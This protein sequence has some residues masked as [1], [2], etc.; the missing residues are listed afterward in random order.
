M[1]QLKTESILTPNFN[2]HFESEDGKTLI[3]LDVLPGRNVPYFYSHKGTHIA[4]IRL[5]NESVQAST[6]DLKRMVLEG[7][8]ETYDS[9]ESKFLFKDLRFTKLKYTYKKITRTDFEDTD[10]ESFNLITSNGKLTN[11]GALL[12]D[13]SPVRHSR[14]FC[15][16]WNGLDKAG[17]LVDALDD[18]EYSGDLITLLEESMHFVARNNKKPWMKTPGRRIEMP[19]YPEQAVQEGI[20]NGLIHRDY[21]VLGSEVHIDIYDDRLEIYSPGGMYDGSLVQNLDP[22]HVS[23]TRRNPI[24]A[25]MFSRLDYMERR[26][27]GFKKI[28]NEY[29]FHPNYKD[30]YMPEF[31]STQSG[32]WLILKNLNYSVAQDVAQD[33]AQGVAQGVAQEKNIDEAIIKLI[34]SNNKITRDEIANVLQVSKKTIERHIKELD[35][36]KYVGSG[37]S[38]HWE[39]DD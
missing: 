3:V 37:Y 16:R 6:S 28:M 26:G 38:G 30:E 2:L 11:A 4:Y 18:A 31:M 23:S 9:L 8:G 29:K 22:W 21:L 17:G 10:F 25:D 7:F 27:S 34:K 19:D 35:N 39:I 1:K 12:A 36:I 33:V 32:F 20:V 15:T 5:G 14:V 13:D 24:I